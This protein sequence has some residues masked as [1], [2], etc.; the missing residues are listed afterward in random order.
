[1]RIC[2]R[3]LIYHAIL[4]LKR[5]FIQLAGEWQVQ[6]MK[7][8]ILEIYALAVCFFAVLCFV[9]SLGLAFWNVIELSVPEFTV[10]NHEYNCHQTNEAYKQCYSS[11]YQYQR[12]EHPETFPSD[13]KLTKQRVADYESILK[14]ERR[15]A[16]QGLV[17]KLIIILIDIF[18]FII[19]WRLAK[20][21]RE[22]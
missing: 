1:M 4:C 10:N 8:T 5:A 12:E 19:H 15:R 22:K 17:Q 20:H 3:A 9:I 18:I 6:G 7:K 13:I 21:A 11:L 14:L 16:L 2:Y